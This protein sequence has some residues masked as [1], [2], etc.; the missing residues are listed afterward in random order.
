MAWLPESSK[1]MQMNDSNRAVWVFAFSQKDGSLRIVGS[2]SE[3]EL[4]TLKAGEFSLER[5]EHGFT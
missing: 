5:F 1:S 2:G 4:G 3:L